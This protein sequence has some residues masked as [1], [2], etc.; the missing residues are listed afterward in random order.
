MLIMYGGADAFYFTDCAA[1]QY[2]KTRT[3]LIKPDILGFTSIVLVA[4]Y[5]RRIASIAE[6]S[7]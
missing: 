1:K 2:K 4:L 7:V 3:V 6:V 5:Y